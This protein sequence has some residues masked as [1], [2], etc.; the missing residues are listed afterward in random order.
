MIPTLT[1]IHMLPEALTI[2]VDDDSR[3]TVP[4]IVQP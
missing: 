3:F 2:T 1:M 4:L